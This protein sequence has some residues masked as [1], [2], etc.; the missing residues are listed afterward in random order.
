MKRILA[1]VGCGLVVAAAAALA[2]D[3]PDCA[4]KYREQWDKRRAELADLKP[5]QPGYLPFPY[6]TTK[7]QVRAD[8]RED[9]MRMRGGERRHPPT[10]ASELTL[11]RAIKTNRFE[12][13]VEHIEN[14]TPGRCN[15]RREARYEILARVFAVPNGEEIARVYLTQEGYLNTWNMSQGLSEDLKAVWKRSVPKAAEGNGLVAGRFGIKATN[16]KL[17]HGT[18]EGSRCFLIRPCVLLEGEAG[19]RYLWVP[20][21]PG[22]PEDELF[23]FDSGSERM[24]LQEVLER[25]SSRGGI[26]SG[27]LAGQLSLSFGAEYHI[28]LKKVEQQ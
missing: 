22:V 20:R 21:M 8:L 4:S 17:I 6:P 3:P 27:K 11:Y 25:A 10:L 14:W 7:D 16:A 18:M 19:R 28:V 13:E 9:Y 26:Q 1:F 5:G 24:S 23:E 2:Q 15:P 12:I